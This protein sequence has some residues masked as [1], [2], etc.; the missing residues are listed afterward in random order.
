MILSE[1]E[2]DISP[3]RDGIIVLGDGWKPGEPLAIALP[4]RARRARARG[5]LEPR[6]PALDARRRAR[7]ARDLR[8]RPG[9]ARRRAS[10]PHSA[11]GST[12]DW[13]TIAIEDEDLCPRFTARVFQDVQV[14]AVAALAQ[15]APERG[16]DAPDLERRRHHELRHARPRQPAP[17]L[18][19]RASC[20]AASLTARR[21]RPGET[22]RTL[23]GQ[24][25]ELDPDDARDRRRR[26]AA[27]HRR[28][29]GRRRLRDRAR[30]DDDRAR[31]RELHARPD[32][33][34][35]AGSSACAP[36]ARTAGRRASTPTSPRSPRVRR[37]G[38]SSS[39]AAPT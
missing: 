11:T 36:T 29:H 33:A 15:G 10:R 7:R 32:H 22:L 17:R 26:G 1:R 6:R 30:H 24:Q 18:R 14:G 4:L 35:L 37:P 34:H 31:G 9:A 23:D 28:H 2:L 27:G 13:I 5:H 39:C 38:C 21:A 3:E 12:A 20:A 19:L 8:H 25:R 16:G